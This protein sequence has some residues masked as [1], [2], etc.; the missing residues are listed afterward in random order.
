MQ[1]TIYYTRENIT[2][3]ENCQIDLDYIELQFALQLKINGKNE[4]DFLELNRKQ[5]GTYPQYKG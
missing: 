1:H 4:K 5:Y 3:I 2:Y